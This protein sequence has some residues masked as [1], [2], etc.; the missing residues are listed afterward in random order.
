MLVVYCYLLYKMHLVATPA[1]GCVSDLSQITFGHFS[2]KSPT[3]LIM[4]LSSEFYQ[5]SG[6]CPANN[7]NKK[8]DMMDI[9]MCNYQW[10][11]F[12][13]WMNSEV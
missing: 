2:G 13:Y 5:K 10:C 12:V 3:F 11:P 7:C 6:L 9:P 1:K 4:S 8:C